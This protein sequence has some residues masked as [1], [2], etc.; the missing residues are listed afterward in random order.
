MFILCIL[1]VCACVDGHLSGTMDLCPFGSVKSV[2]VSVSACMSG[3]VYTPSVFQLFDLSNHHTC[4]TI[5]WPLDLLTNP[6]MQLVNMDPTNSVTWE[7]L[8]Q[9]SSM[10]H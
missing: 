9:I 3:S 10:K 2:W 8:Q 1:C 5:A 4:D 6:G 7:Q